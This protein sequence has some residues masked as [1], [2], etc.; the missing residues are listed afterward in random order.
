M[1]ETEQ[2]VTKRRAAVLTYLARG[3]RVRVATPYGET[4]EGT[5]V[6]SGDNE[7]VQVR[8]WD[9]PWSLIEHYHWTYLQPATDN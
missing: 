5:V 9:K 2:Y 8:R 4:G 3:A 1:T 6:W 7:Y